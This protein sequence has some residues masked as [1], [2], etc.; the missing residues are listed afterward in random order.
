MFLD[1]QEV[2]STLSTN[3]ETMKSSTSNEFRNK[4][5]LVAKHK[6]SQ[7]KEAQRLRDLNELQQNLITIQGQSQE[8]AQLKSH[9]ASVIATFTA[10]QSAERHS[11]EIERFD[12]RTQIDDLKIIQ[13]SLNNTVEAGHATVLKLQRQL[14]DA[15]Q[16]PGDSSTSNDGRKLSQLERRYEIL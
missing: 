15:V 9:L 12:F 2:K 10:S 1:D 13:V 3:D 6:S 8:V 5:K 4:Q 16:I 7:N 11:R 14:S